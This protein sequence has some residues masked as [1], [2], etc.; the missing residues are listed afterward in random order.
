LKGEGVELMTLTLREA[1]GCG[2]SAL[3]TLDFATQRNAVV[4]ER[5]VDSR[6]L[7]ALFPFLGGQ[8]T[9]STGGAKSRAEREAAER[10]SEGHLVSVLCSLCHELSG[11]YRQRLLGKF[12]EAGFEKTRRLVGIRAV[13]AERVHAFESRFPTRADR[14]DDDDD[15]EAEAAEE[16]AR[17]LGRI[18]AGLLT[19]QLATTV[20]AY[21]IAS[22]DPVLSK[23]VLLLLHESGVSLPAAVATVAELRDSMGDEER[24]GSVVTNNRRKMEALCTQLDALCARLV[25]RPAPL[26]PR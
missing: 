14:D 8:A 4:C 26:E 16:E 1:N 17:Y 25:R 3:K 13:Y 7:G 22:G 11:T 15:D 9:L 18:D 6:G 12:V 2:R 24:E 19:V 21:L 20:L 5:F 10:E 23:E